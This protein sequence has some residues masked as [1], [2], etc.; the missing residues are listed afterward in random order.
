[1]CG[2]VIGTAFGIAAFRAK[3]NAFGVEKDAADD[4][5]Y[6]NEVVLLCPRVDLVDFRGFVL[7]MTT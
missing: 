2:N 1:M 4:P 3:E 5:L 6:W 7:Q